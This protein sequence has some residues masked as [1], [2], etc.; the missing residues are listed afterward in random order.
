M[1]QLS[2]FIGKCM[3]HSSR[4]TIHDIVYRHLLSLLLYPVCDLHAKSIAF[5]KFVFKYHEAFCEL[6]LQ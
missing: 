5:A 6:N 4:C 2:L 3:M 1:P